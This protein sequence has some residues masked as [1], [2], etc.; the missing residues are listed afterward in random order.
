MI[1]SITNTS[2]VIPLDYEHMCTYNMREVLYPKEL[3]SIV[4][5]RS[6]LQGL[7][8]LVTADGYANPP[9]K[10]KEFF[11]QIVNDFLSLLAHQLGRKEQ[12]SFVAAPST[13]KKDSV[14]STTIKVVQELDLPVVY[15]TGGKYYSPEYVNASL[16]PP[17]V[18]SARFK[19]EPKYVLPTPEDSFYAGSLISTS[20]ILFG[21]RDLTLLDFIYTVNCDRKVV[22]VVDKTNPL[23][24]YDLKG[25]QNTTLYL[26]ELIQYYR[27]HGRFEN[28]NLPDYQ[29]IK[30]TLKD[31]W[32]FIDA[33]VLIVELNS[34][35]ELSSLVTKAVKFLTE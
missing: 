11:S 4:D 26:K 5:E 3:V 21:G 30:K 10:Y 29:D 23:S 18:D 35:D 8:H 25:L 9:D 7:R 32:G 27:M 13:N 6:D 12:V 14:D 19:R 17:G 31:R 1:K 22:L 33:N 16:L 28:E 15:L 2:R 34:E 20:L 24:S